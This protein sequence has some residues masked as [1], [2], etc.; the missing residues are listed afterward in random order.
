M[1]ICNI[2]AELV[3]LTA[4]LNPDSHERSG[5]AATPCNHAE[6]SWLSGFKY[7]V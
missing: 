1:V 2:I 3:V 7:A 5:T 4:Y 6:P